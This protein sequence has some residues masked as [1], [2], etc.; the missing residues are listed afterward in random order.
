MVVGM[1]LAQKRIGGNWRSQ[2]GVPIPL[3]PKIPVA[4]CGDYEEIPLSPRMPVADCGDYEEIPLSP[5]KK[6]NVFSLKNKNLQ[7]K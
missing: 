7:R 6:Q 2:G 5:Q 3:S 4:D 1:P